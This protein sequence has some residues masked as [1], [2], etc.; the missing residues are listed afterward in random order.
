M[1]LTRI[2]SILLGLF[3]SCHIMVALPSQAIAGGGEYLKLIDIECM[4]IQDSGEDEVYV[5][6]DKGNGN[7]LTF[8]PTSNTG[9][10]EMKPE[11]TETMNVTTQLLQEIKL[12]LMEYDPTIFDEDEK[13][14]EI[15]ISEDSAI[16][17]GPV[18]TWMAKEQ[19]AKYKIQYQV[20]EDY[21]PCKGEIVPND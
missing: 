18:Q 12:T 8:W 17:D 4:S 15:T 9:Y 3:V 2:V 13:L 10:Q 14:G 16:V 1:K 21:Q 5:M 19:G 20:C 11:D 6:Y 7:T